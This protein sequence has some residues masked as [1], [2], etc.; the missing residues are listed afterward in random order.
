MIYL[1]QSE[2]RVGTR[3]S[4]DLLQ[5][6]RPCIGLE[7][8]TGADLLISPVEPPLP[9][10]VNRPPGS[11]LLRKHTEA[12]ML[13][14]R[15]SGGDMLGSIPK[16]SSILQRMQ[17]WDSVCWLL[18]C[19]KFQ[20]DHDECVIADGHRSGWQWASLQGAL[21]A[22]QLRGG[23]INHEP[24][25]DFGAHWLNR[26]DL[27]IHKLRK[28]AIGHMPVQKIAGG[29]F[30][31][32]P[33]KLTLQSFPD[34]GEELSRQIAGYCST[35]MH[36]IWWMTDPTAPELKG[37][38]PKR[39]EV[40]RRWLGLRDGELFLPIMAEDRHTVEEV[41]MPPKVLAESLSF[42]MADVKELEPA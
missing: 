21:D 2:G 34:C 13:I 9:D 26:W 12:G 37:I 33:W 8:Q 29:M 7:A 4:K 16:L 5:Y 32:Q 14:Q 28:D 39:K 35:L 36:S 1:D 22:W 38:G 17:Q 24:D 25:D 27:N 18:V 41:S 6:S 15:K 42:T 20:P 19:G 23:L 40:W 31:P 30:D 11:L 3:L 10:N